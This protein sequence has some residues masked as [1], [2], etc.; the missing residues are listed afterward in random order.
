MD[1]LRVLI[2]FTFTMSLLALGCACAVVFY[3][4]GLPRRGN[5]KAGRGLEGDPRNLPSVFLLSEWRAKTFL[6]ADS[7]IP[8]CG[9]NIEDP[10]CTIADQIKMHEQNGDG[11]G[12]LYFLSN[13]VISYYGK[14][15]GWRVP[16]LY[17]VAS[18]VVAFSWEDQWW[19][20]TYPETS[21]LMQFAIRDVEETD[22][23]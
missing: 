6:M 15:S 19:V 9:P 23:E 3:V 22:R 4:V 5:K 1:D 10:D 17:R 11:I 7:Q 18:S 14:P 8:L 13:V 21:R 2:V 16:S 12:V 20:E